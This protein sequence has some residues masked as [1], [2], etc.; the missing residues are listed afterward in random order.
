MKVGMKVD[1]MVELKGYQKV[2]EMDKY[3]VFQMVER[4]VDG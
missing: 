3:W 2:D 1:V 4:W